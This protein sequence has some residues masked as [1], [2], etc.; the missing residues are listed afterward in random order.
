MEK[1]HG[2]PPAYKSIGKKD[3]VVYLAQGLVYLPHALG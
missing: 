3:A 1:R 2:L